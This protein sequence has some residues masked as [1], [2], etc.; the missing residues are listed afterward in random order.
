MFCRSVF[1]TDQPEAVRAEL[2]A[3]PE[4]RVT[5]RTPL[6]ARAR[7][8]ASVSCGSDWGIEGNRLCSKPRRRSG[9]RGPRLARVAVGRSRAVPRD[10]AGDHRTDDER[11][12]HRGRR[13]G[14]PVAPLPTCPTR[15]APCASCSIGTTTMDRSAGA[16]PRQPLTTRGGAHA[17]CG[18]PS[19]STCSSSS[20]TPPRAARRGRPAGLRLRELDLAGSLSWGCS[21]RVPS[22]REGC[23]LIRGEI[24]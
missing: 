1:E 19:S 13:G 14:R 4:I 6:L 8:R 2:A 11:A 12:A 20:K 7:R 9:P 15:T 24:S 21:S 18:G 3:R 17:R 16:G 22:S 10:G 23:R 5:G